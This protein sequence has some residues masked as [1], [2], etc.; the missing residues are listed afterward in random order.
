MFKRVDSGLNLFVVLKN[1]LSKYK[2]K[3]F[4]EIILERSRLQFGDPDEQ[5]RCG[6]CGERKVCRCNKIKS[7]RKVLKNLL[8]VHFGKLKTKC[9]KV[10][11]IFMIRWLTDVTNFL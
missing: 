2:I 6:F 9:I 10:I 11:I 3:K 8:S 7:M 4:N 1:K 5:V